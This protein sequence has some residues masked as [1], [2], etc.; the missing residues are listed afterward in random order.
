MIQCTIVRAECYENTPIQLSCRV[1]HNVKGTVSPTKAPA[2]LNPK[3]TA[4]LS[5]ESHSL[6]LFDSQ[7]EVVSY[8]IYNSMG[9]EIDNGIINIT[10]G[11]V[12]Y[13]YL[14]VLD[15]GVY[16]ILLVG[17]NIIYEGTFSL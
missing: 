15:Q 8:T 6:S 12:A 1:I 16:S 9:D 3:I 11:N 4:F 10:S 2:R 17:G 5:E 13:V 7:T 14:G